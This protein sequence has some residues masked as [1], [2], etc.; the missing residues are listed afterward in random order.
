M[1]HY[2]I[3]YEKYSQN[4]P[5][6]FS[7]EI[8]FSMSCIES[9]VEINLAPLDIQG[10]IGCQTNSNPSLF[11]YGGESLKAKK[12]KKLVSQNIDSQKLIELLLSEK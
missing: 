10:Y 7:E 12:I 5:Q 6:R 11:H 9:S 3:V 1:L 8:I 2:W 4:L